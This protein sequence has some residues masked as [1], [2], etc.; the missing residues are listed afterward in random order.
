MSAHND[1]VEH[2]AATLASRV[3]DFLSKEPGKGKRALERMEEAL[4]AFNEVRI[5]NRPCGSCPTCEMCGV[6]RSKK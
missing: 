2:S 4:F 5:L 1:C 3:T 6:G